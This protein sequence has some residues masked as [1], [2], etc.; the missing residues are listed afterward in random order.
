MQATEN[1]E[2]LGGVFISIRRQLSRIV[3]RIVPPKDIEDIVQETYVRVCQST[4]GKE[5]RSP[6]SFMVQTAKNL[7]FDH[8]RRHEHRFASSVEDDLNK[9]YGEADQGFNA[10]YEETVSDEEFGEFCEAVRLL[11]LQC[12]RVFVLK[13]VYGYSQREIA[14]ELGISESTAEK[15]VS[16]GVRRCTEYMMTKAERSTGQ[17]SAASRNRNEPG[18]RQ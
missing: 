17:S 2:R 16:L 8:I 6:R 11:P 1:H 7:A 10:P 4:G 5:I 13:K 15:H 18:R 12:R 9:G 3:A 14:K